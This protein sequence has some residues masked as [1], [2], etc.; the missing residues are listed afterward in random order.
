MPITNPINVALDIPP[1]DG[2]VEVELLGA[3]A[4]VLMVAGGGGGDAS[5]V[6]DGGGGGDAS[7][8]TDGGGGGDVT[9][10]TATS[11]GEEAVL[12]ITGEAAGDDIGAKVAAAAYSSRSG[13]DLKLR[14]GVSSFL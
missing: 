4:V 9:L 14:L 1:S 6:T 8:V 13:E 3:G 12:L 7:L 11:G 10:V 5:L 2:E